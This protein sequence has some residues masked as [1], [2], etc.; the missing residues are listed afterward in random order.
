MTARLTA[1]PEKQEELSNTLKAL[2][3]GI[4]AQAGC[5]DSL[6]GRELSREARF[7]LHS[8]WADA[9]SLDV[10]LAS[11]EFG[12]LRGASSILTDPDGFLLFVASHP[13]SPPG[14]LPPPA[15]GSSFHPLDKD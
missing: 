8:I 14:A 12:V 15:P 9:A 13:E 3:L 11:D 1:R 4:R 6:V 2:T 7:I 10:F 5:L